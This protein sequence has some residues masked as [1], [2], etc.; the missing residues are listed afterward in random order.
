MKDRS[1]HRLSNG[2]RPVQQIEVSESNVKKRVIAMIIF[3][4]IGVTA[5]GFF[6]HSLLSTEPGWAQIEVNA[7]GVSCGEDF[8]FN[9]YLGGGEESATNEKKQ[10][11]ALYS[12]AAVKA[13]KLFDRYSGYDGV[14]NI[15]YINTHVGETV[16]VDKI[17][18]KAFELLEEK[19]SRYLYFGPLYAEYINMYFSEGSLSSEDNDPYIDPEFA[20]IFAEMAAYACDEEA[21]KL[22]LL[23]DDKVRLNVS[24]KYLSYAEENGI[25]VFIDFFRAKNAFIIDYLA[26]TMIENGFTRGSISSYDGYVRNLDSGD[27]EYSLNLFDKNGDYIYNTATMTY[28]GRR[29]IVSLRSYSMG[30]KDSYDFHTKLDGTVITPYIDNSGLYKAA[31]DNVISYS[32]DLGC[33]EVLLEMLSWYIADEFDESALQTMK[34]AGIYSVWFEGTTICYNDE[35]IGLK[36]IYDNEGVKYAPG[37]V[38]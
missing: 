1:K 18:Y 26:D 6:V 23:G 5:L 7:A 25:E 21:I 9:Y 29:A 20:A 37:Y 11:T 2:A 3:L 10:L 19:G 27:G 36:D 16:K 28:Q 14:N 32:G 17:L 8:I 31:T 15:Y 13:Y 34:D 30:E 35:D 38:E 4:A 12:A 24:T 33:S 22:E